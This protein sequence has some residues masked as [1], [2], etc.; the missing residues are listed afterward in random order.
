MLFQPGEALS[1]KPLAPKQVPPSAVFTGAA[2]DFPSLG[3]LSAYR[4]VL[5]Y[6]ADLDFPLVFAQGAQADFGAARRQ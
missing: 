4:G 5:R 3:L 2:I 1:K 6:E